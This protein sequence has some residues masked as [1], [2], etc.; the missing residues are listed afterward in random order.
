MS[1]LTVADVLSLSHCSYDSSF[2]ASLA[3]K[4]IEAPMW[5][6]DGVANIQPGGG[7]WLGHVF[8]GSLFVFWA[9]HWLLGFVRQYFECQRQGR[10]YTSKTCYRFLW[11]PESWPLEAITKFLMPIVNMLLEVWLAHIGLEG[12]KYLICP[13]GTSRA[14]HIYG[15]NIGNWQHA[16]MYPGFIVSGVI[17]L[18]HTWVEIPHGLSLVFL[19][20]GLATPTFMMFIHNQFHAPFDELVHS[21]LFYTL[22]TTCICTLAE[23]AWP[24]N[25]LLTTGRIAGMFLQGAWFIGAARMLYDGN[26][27]PWDTVGDTDM[28]PL[29]YAPI[30]YLILVATVIVGILAVF[31]LGYIIYRPGKWESRMGKSLEN[32]HD[33][34]DPHQRLG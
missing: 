26:T 17:D 20:L 9:S 34:E 14:G 11:F 29:M 31:M 6:C 7:N 5:E 32:L 19:G 21:L 1:D 27:A 28:S 16:F 10:P 23:S 12:Y 25:P 8:P 4:F 2:C 24:H 13:S 22:C 33:E 18:V 3:E 30:L 15:E